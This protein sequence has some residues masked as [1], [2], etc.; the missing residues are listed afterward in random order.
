MRIGGFIRTTFIDYPGRVAAAVFTRGCNLRCPY[1]HNPGL[2]LSVGSEQDD[3]DEV[4]ILGFLSRRRRQLDGV[5]LTGGEPTLQSDLP[6]FLHTLKTWDYAVKLDTN[7]THPEVLR[8]LLDRNLVDFVA[9]DLKA[10]FHT[11]AALAGVEVD[12]A[13]VIESMDLVR[14]ADIDHEFRTTCV[15]PALTRADLLDIATQLHPLER[16]VLQ[17]YRPGR[18][19]DPNFAA[20]ATPMPDDDLESTQSRIH[21]LGLNC[22]IR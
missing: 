3:L 7:G 15:S 8:D 4:E 20:Q 16:Y 17:R 11:Y 1:C 10:P 5:V 19:L 21:S 2:V 18:T 9:M 13:A 12:T 6:D 22:V 14:S